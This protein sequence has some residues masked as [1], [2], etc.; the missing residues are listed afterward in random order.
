M[1]GGRRN[2]VL[3][4]RHATNLRDL[5]RELSRRQNAPVGRLGPLADLDLDHPDRIV[6]GRFRK[7]IWIESAVPAAT[8]E[9]A[10]PD[11]PRL[12]RRSAS[13]DTG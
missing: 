12:D 6:P 9:I 13:S 4:H 11:L 2:H 3:A 8:A 10:G 5:A 1:V 7:E